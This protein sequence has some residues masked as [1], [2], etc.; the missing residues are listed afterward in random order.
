MSVSFCLVTPIILCGWWGVQVQHS[1]LLPTHRIVSQS[2]VSSKSATV[3]V[4]LFLFHCVSF[5]LDCVDFFLL[6]SY[7]PSC[8]STSL[9]TT[10]VCVCVCV[11]V[12]ARVCVC[13]RLTPVCMCVC[14]HLYVCVCAPV[15]V[16]VHLYLCVCTCMCMHLYVCVCV[17]STS[18][19]S[20]TSNMR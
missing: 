3:S 15:C 6:P 11:C 9:F 20:C 5:M 13:V 10:C 7:P 8:T 16:C 12:C 4:D 2:F 19:T 14:V 17:C 18:T 1:C